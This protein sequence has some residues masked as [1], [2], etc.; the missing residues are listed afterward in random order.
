ML[1]LS[2]LFKCHLAACHVGHWGWL[3]VTAMN[4]RSF[5]PAFKPWHHILCMGSAR[6]PLPAWH[7]DAWHC[8]NKCSNGTGSYSSACI[9]RYAPHTHTPSVCQP[10]TY[11]NVI[12]CQINLSKYWTPAYSWLRESVPLKQLVIFLSVKVA[13]CIWP[14]T[15]A[16]FFPLF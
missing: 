7:P 6:P 16:L 11:T 12:K 1:A 8:V 5:V 4:S 13:F 14:L 10:V 2:E 9:H 3:T 15:Q